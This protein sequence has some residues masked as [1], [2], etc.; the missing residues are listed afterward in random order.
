MVLIGNALGSMASNGTG[1]HGTPTS[2]KV[3]LVVRAAPASA[4]ASRSVPQHAL[5]VDG[6]RVGAR[7]F[8][9]AGGEPN[10]SSYGG[11]GAALHRPPC[12]L[13]TPAAPPPPPSSSRSFFLPFFPLFAVVAIIPVV[14]GRTAPPPSPPHLSCAGADAD[15]DWS[16][17][18]APPPP[19]RRWAGGL[20]QSGTKMSRK[21]KNSIEKYSRVAH[22]SR[23]AGGGDIL[24]PSR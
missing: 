2:S 8:S 19:P 4:P 9:S 18:R 10:W 15:P 1:M 11:T 20:L 13:D 22:R 7:S 12:T 16:L 21:A 17:P 5:L 14:S 24:P 23:R 3:S 6:R